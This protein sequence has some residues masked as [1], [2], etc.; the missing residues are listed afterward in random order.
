MA[1]LKLPPHNPMTFKDKSKEKYMDVL[2]LL[3]PNPMSF[4]NKFMDVLKINRGQI[5]GCPKY[6]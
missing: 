5:C 1:V 4:L 3:A 2:N 6:S